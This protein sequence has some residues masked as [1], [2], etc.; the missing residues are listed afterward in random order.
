MDCEDLLL[1]DADDAVGGAG[2]ALAGAGT[3]LA[4]DAGA[5]LADTGA[6]V[7]TGTF[8]AGLTGAFAAGASF[9]SLVLVAP[10]AGH[11]AAGSCLEDAWTGGL[12]S[13]AAKAGVDPEATF[14]GTVPALGVTGGATGLAATAAGGAV[15]VVFPS[16]RRS[17]LRASLT[18]GIGGAE[19]DTEAAEVVGTADKSNGT[20]VC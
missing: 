14:L 12:T 1:D 9:V 18:V 20:K 16:R 19:A 2:C 11:E 3:V 6:L 7:G 13:G 5:T 15:T 17:R 10:S 8:T 4:L